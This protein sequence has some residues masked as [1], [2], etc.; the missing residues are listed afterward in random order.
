MFES[1]LFRFIRL[2]IIECIAPLFKYQWHLAKDKPKTRPNPYVEMKNQDF[3]KNLCQ[4]IDEYVWVL[5]PSIN[6][7]T[8]IC[9]AFVVVRL[10]VESGEY[11]FLI[12]GMHV[13]HLSSAIERRINPIT[14]MNIAT[15]HLVKFNVTVLYSL[16]YIYT[17]Q[18]KGYTCILV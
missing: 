11:I 16:W 17:Q 15:Y 3:E 9:A 8:M 14:S 10:F 1:F 7:F 4:S 6:L 13:K 5:L 18:N 2:I 12:L